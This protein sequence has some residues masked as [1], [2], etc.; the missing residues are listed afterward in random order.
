VTEEEIAAGAGNFAYPYAASRAQPEVRQAIVRFRRLPIAPESPRVTTPLLYWLLGQ[1]TPAFKMSQPDA[2]YGE[3]RA[4]GQTC[5]NCLFA[6]QHVT[7]KSFICSEMAGR[8]LPSAWCRLW[9]P[10]G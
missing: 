5:G 7:S 4:P 6:Y 2:L 8:I 10:G 9:K 1:G 3:P